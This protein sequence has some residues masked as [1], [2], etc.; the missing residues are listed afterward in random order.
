MQL[1]AGI[2]NTVMDVVLVIL[3]MVIV[4]R[5]RSLPRRQMVVVVGLFA[6]GWLVSLAGAVRTYLLFKQTTTPDHDFTWLSWVSYLA[7]S[8][9]LNLGIVSS[10]LG[11]SSTHPGL[12]KA[13]KRG[14]NS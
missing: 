11:R 2:W 3:P 4:L 13:G 14:S 9:E 12:R 6:M 1:N 5:L 7:S 10:A 8:V